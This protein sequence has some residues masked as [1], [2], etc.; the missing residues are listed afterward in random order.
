MLIQLYTMKGCSMCDT[1]KSILDEE[2]PYRTIT[3]MS[4]VSK[5]AS[6]LSLMSMPILVVDGEP[7]SG[8]GAKIKA[9]QLI[10]ESKI[11]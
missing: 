9:Q 10:K 11:G 5:K 7:F 8:R 2:I 4:E 3:N 1:V 6:E